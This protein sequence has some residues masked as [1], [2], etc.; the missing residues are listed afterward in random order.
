VTEQNG[1]DNLVGDGFDEFNNITGAHDSDG[2]RDD[3]N[4]SAWTT[5][6]WFVNN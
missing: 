1:K 4:D 2:H 3:L 5:P 6:I